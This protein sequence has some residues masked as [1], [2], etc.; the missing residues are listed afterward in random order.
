[1]AASVLNNDSHPLRGEF[2]LLPSGRR[3]LV[4]K[5]R[6][7]RY[8]N[9]FVPVA[10]TELNK[11][12]WHSTLI[13]IYLFIDLVFYPIYL[14]YLLSWRLP[15]LLLFLLI[16][17]YVLLRV[18][19]SIWSHLFIL[20]LIHAATLM[21]GEHWALS[22]LSLW[23]IISLMCGFFCLLWEALSAKQIYPRVWIK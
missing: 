21:S 10:V 12:L 15:L 5:C 9:S 8:K 16:L 1:M 20:L 4:P 14:P 22:V 23:S 17:Q 6:T 18:V 13:L 19:L 3:F 7:Q 2:R 11:K